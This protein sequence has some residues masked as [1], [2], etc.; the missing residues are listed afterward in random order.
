MRFEQE[1]KR[2]RESLFLG[3]HR[4]LS[5]RTVRCKNSPIVK[6]PMSQSEIGVA[7]IGTGFGQKVHIPGFQAHH[8]TRIVA[9]YHQGFAK[10]NINLM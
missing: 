2:D 8:Q 4:L 5:F 1:Q 7:I 3:C 10:A 9:V 6:I